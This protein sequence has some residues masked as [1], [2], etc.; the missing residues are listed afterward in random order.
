MK[1]DDY[2][3]PELQ[4]RLAEDERVAELGIKVN[5]RPEG[6]LMLSGEVESE[7][8]RARI[9]QVV[10]EEFP[11]V[12]VTWDIGVTRVHEPEEVEEL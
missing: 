8:R 5:R 4:R 9:K 1:V 11:G 10:A 6:G 3:E 12:D 7:Q 2:T